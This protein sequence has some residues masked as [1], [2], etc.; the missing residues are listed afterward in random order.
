MSD[1]IDLTNERRRRNATTGKNFAV[2]ST[3]TLCDMIH[4]EQLVNDKEH[5]VLL[6]SPSADKA[7]GWAFTPEQ[8]ERI[9]DVLR[10]AAARAREASE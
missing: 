7:D 8:A 4:T 1:V 3:D 6:I 2:P 5:S 10:A 9:A